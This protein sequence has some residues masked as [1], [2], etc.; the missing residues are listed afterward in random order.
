MEKL[1]NGIVLP[2]VWPPQNIEMDS[3]H[4]I[5]VPYLRQKPDVIDISIG[6]QLF[7][8]DFLIA[9][10]KYLYP[11]PHKAIKYEG[12]PV[13]VPITETECATEPC[14][15]PKSGG[16]WYD[17]KAGKYK[18]WY[19]AG[20]LHR[21]AYAES[22]DGIH[23]DRPNLDIVEGTNRILKDVVADSS[24]VFMDH[25][26]DPNERYKLFIRSPDIDYHTGERHVHGYVAVSSD[27][28]HWERMT[29]TSNLGDRSTIFYNPFRKKWVYSI[30]KNTGEVTAWRRGT[31][32]RVRE[33]RE[34]DDLLEGAK[35][36]H[37]DGTRENVN[38]MRTD[39]RDLRDPACGDYP[40]LYNFDAV[41]YESIML[42]LF[43]IHKGPSNPV[44][45]KGG[46]PKLTELI[47][48]YSRDGFHFSRPDREAFIPASREVG[49]W[50]RG[51]V[52]SVGGVCLI[53]GDELWFYYIGFEG[54]DRRM[55][56]PKDIDAKHTNAST[57]IAKLRR[58][59]FVSMDGTGWL[60][61]ERL[62]VA[63]GRNKLFI[64]AKAIHG[65]VRAAL[66]DGNG[67]VLEGYSEDDCVPFVGNSTC[68]RITWKNKETC[69]LPNVFRVRFHQRNAQLYAFWFSDSEKGDSHGYNAAGAPI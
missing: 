61:T 11:F 28:I 59:G 41:A 4:E 42:G 47:A 40:Q 36:I 44:C 39:V 26:A 33:Y 55:L 49:E 60:K 15:C 38:W 12:N 7:V 58:D 45:D 54:D 16:V 9:E 6:R 57:G 10:S 66:L 34:C 27:G 53:H 52:Q 3:P 65:E 30:R 50:D 20:W 64:N 31:N 67:E 19:E 29:P 5:D 2:D 13:F 69:A 23:W 43:Q 21:M 51:Y 35:W 63:E 62:S 24:T 22:E 32:D 8:D 18:M 48:S 37:E 14:A 46:F 56:H 68:A 25:E 17:E 1:Y